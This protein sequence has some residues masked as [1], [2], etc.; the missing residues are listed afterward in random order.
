[1]RSLEKTDKK[2]KQ[3]NQQRQQQPGSQQK[4]QGNQPNKGNHKIT[5]KKSAAEDGN[6]RRSNG[7]RKREN[8]VNVKRET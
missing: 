8:D 6:H 2:R 5:A 1:L 4:Q 7:L 3:Q